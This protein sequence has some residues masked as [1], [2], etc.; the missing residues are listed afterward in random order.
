MNHLKSIIIL[1]LPIEDILK[2]KA[3]YKDSIQIHSLL[4]A[5]DQNQILYR[6][7]RDM[8]RVW[9]RHQI[10]QLDLTLKD[11]D[12]LC[13]Q[14]GKM[15]LKSSQLSSRIT[16][17]RSGLKASTWDD[18]S[19]DIDRT[20]D[21]IAGTWWSSDGS[22]CQEKVDWLLYD[23]GT[24]AVITRISIATFKATFHLNS[25]IYGFKKC[26]IELGFNTEEF[27]YKTKEFICLNTDELQNFTTHEHLDNILPTARYIK[28]WMQGCHQKQRIDDRWYFAIND[29]QVEGIPLKCFPQPVPKILKVSGDLTSKTKEWLGVSNRYQQEVTKHLESDE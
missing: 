8:E 21:G 5:S 19:Q 2:V 26:W 29:F 1:F 24:V 15:Q 28:F 11:C 14:L 7:T 13:I 3:L 6:F 22:D 12:K 16:T 20:L 25:P 4:H 18:V 17:R 10:S 23:L 27:H 9:S